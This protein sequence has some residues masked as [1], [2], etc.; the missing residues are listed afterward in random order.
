M[1]SDEIVI[2]CAT[3][4][5]VPATP[6]TTNVLEQVVFDWST[7]VNNG[8]PVTSYKVLIRQSD[9]QYEEIIDYCNGAQSIIVTV[10]ECTI[11]LST[12]TSEP[13]NLVLNDSIDAMVEAYNAYG[14]SGFSAV[15]GGAL[16]QYVPDAP[17]DLTT[18]PDSTSATQVSFSWSDGL[19]DGGAAV[20]DYRI[21]Y[22]QSTGTWTELD[23]GITQK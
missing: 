19:S 23:A 15:G 16:I 7:P 4:P 20:I 21:Y 13:F 2:L 12:L 6:T 10:T 18:E 17:I 9:N 8:L 14:T 5:E 1:Y 11:P 3:V 22:D